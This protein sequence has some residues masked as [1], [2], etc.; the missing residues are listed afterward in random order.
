MFLQLFESRID[1]VFPL[2]SHRLLC[3]GFHLLH[4]DSGWGFK[5]KISLSNNTSRD[6]T[7]NIHRFATSGT[8]PGSTK[9][10]SDVSK[11]KVSSDEILSEDLHH[12]HHHHGHHGVCVLDCHRYKR[13]RQTAPESQWLWCPFVK[14]F[15][16]S[17]FFVLSFCP[18]VS[19]MLR[20]SC[21]FWV[22]SLSS[23]CGFDRWLRAHNSIKTL[24]F[25]LRATQQTAIRAAMCVAGQHV[26]V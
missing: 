6:V 18:R 2:F 20:H 9:C 4:W 10:S 1:S 22:I 24:I 17:S 12:H 23:P 8:A 13:R 5:G 26:S 11:G 14:R 25:L 15:P 3:V 7:V 19:P 16:P 21:L